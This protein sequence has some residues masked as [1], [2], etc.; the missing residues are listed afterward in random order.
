MA[1]VRD[2][3]TNSTHLIHAAVKGDRQRTIGFNSLLLSHVTE[4]GV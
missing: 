4:T 3:V 2:N 1:T